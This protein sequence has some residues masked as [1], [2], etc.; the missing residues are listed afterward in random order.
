MSRFVNASA[1][2]R[3]VLGDCECPGKPHD[4]DWID[5]RSE[6]GA[7]DILLLSAGSSIDALQ[8]LAVDWN[9]IDHD[10]TTARLDRDH[11]ERLATDTPIFNKLAGWVTKHTAVNSLPNASGAPSANGLQGSASAIQTIPTRR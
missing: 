11:L 1:T 9:L 10:G 5:L 3:I 4:E 2:E 7:Q 8:I 6:L